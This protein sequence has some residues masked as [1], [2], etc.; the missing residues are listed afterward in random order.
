[1]SKKVFISAL[2]WGLGHATRCVPIIKQL[3]KNNN[4]V[5]LGVTS[6][7]SEIFKEEFPNLQRVNMP[8]FNIKYS[9]FMP[10]W[11]SVLLNYF[12]FKNIVNIEKEFTKK[13]VKQFSLDVLISDSRYGLYSDKTKNI[14]I[15][16]QLWIK[17]P[18]FEKY[19]NAIN[20][21]WLSNFDELWVPDFKDD[22]NNLTGKLSHH[23][24]LNKTIKFI[25]PLSRLVITSDGK[26]N[27][28]DLLFLLS[29]PEPKRSQLEKDVLKYLT[30]ITD[31]KK[32]YCL[33]RGTNTS[34]LNLNHPSLTV[35]NLPSRIDLEKIISSSKTILCRSGYSTIMDLFNSQKNIYLVPTT[36]QTEQE[37]LANYLDGKFTFRKISKLSEI[38]L[39]FCAPKKMNY[40]ISNE[41]FL[42]AINNI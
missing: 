10:V 26:N 8:E 13:I 31:D 11:L 5:I 12:S 19:I 24:L 4:Q 14:F 27:Q 41:N 35:F 3:L 37:Y 40:N 2:D 28:Y 32:K 15:T 39:N 42:N 6:I 29:G 36:G 33:V 23:V 21:L 1:M 9:A 7:T 25:E 16:H 34:N 30:N 20:H 18:F 22:V 38:K 17:S